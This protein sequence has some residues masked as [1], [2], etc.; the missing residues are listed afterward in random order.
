MRVREVMV[1]DGEVPP[2]GREGVDEL[3]EAVFRY[4]QNDVQPMPECYS[5]S[6]GD[7]IELDDGRRFVV[8]GF[9]FAPFD[10]DPQEAADA[11][12]RALGLVA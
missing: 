2:L 10:G 7:V 12:A 4:G 5:L 11:R 6:V 3:L 9:G 1:P 8:G